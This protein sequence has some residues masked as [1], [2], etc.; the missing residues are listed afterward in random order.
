M[1]RPD[2][3]FYPEQCANGHEWGL[4]LITVSW[5]I[6]DCGPAVAARGGASG[7]VTALLSGSGRSGVAKHLRVA[8]PAAREARQGPC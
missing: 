8:P 6:C 2:W 1:R 4:G 3:W 5:L 7:A